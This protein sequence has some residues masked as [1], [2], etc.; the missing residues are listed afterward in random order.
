MRFL[1]AALLVAA[2]MLSG[3]ARAAA[4]WEKA[5]A[6]QSMMEIIEQLRGGLQSRRRLRE[7]CAYHAVM[8]GRSAEF[9]ARMAAGLEISADSGVERLWE[10]SAEEIFGSVLNGREMAAFAS[11]G[12]ALA[13]GQAVDEGAQLSLRRL[14]KLL[15]AAEERA[16]RDGRLYTGM[17]MAV[18]AML[19]IMLV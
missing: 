3:R 8:E 14:E 7:I 4:C 2:G 1:G 19:S 11:F 9:F 16:N 10:Q 6:I 13:S 15:N 17:G 5:A 18:G 12:S